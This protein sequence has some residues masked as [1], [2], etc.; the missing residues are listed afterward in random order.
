VGDVDRPLLVLGT[1][2]LAVEIA[3]VASET[4]GFRVAGFVENMDPDRALETLEGLPIH[5]IEDLGK[6][7]ETHVAVCGLAT[8]HRSRFVEE[9]AAAGLGFATVVHPTAR[10]S[11]TSTVGEGAVVSVGVIV[12]SHTTLGSHVLANRGALVGHHTQVGD[13]VSIQPGANVAGACSIGDAAYVGM[14]AVVLDHLSVGAHAVV[15]AGAVVTRDVPG[16]A[17]VVGVPARI[18]KEGSEGL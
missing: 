2:T 5:W 9:A 13:Y 15:G 3:D 18:V 1:R 6:L 4:P 14:G 17:Q 11:P 8:T 12:G 16:R 7:V 10:I